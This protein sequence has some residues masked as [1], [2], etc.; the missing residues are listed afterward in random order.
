MTAGA[1]S[2]TVVPAGVAT[3]NPTLRRAVNAACVEVC[4]GRSPEVPEQPGIEAELV[5]AV[6]FHRIAPL[7][8]VALRETRPDLAALLREDRDTALMH[9]VRVTTSL[10][11]ISKTLGDVPWVTFKGPVLSET[12]H[13]A[14]GLRSYGDL[15][16]LVG[17][18]DLREACERLFAVGW[19]AL[20]TQD[21]LLNGEVTGELEIGRT[22][23]ALV[24]LHWSLLLSETQRRR[25]QV[26]TTDLVARSTPLMIGP[27]EVRTLDP[28]DTLLHL[29]HHAARSGAVR[30]VHLLDVDQAARRIL[31]W[32]L[33]ARRARS[34]QA[35][36]QVGLVLARARRVMDTPVPADLDR[37]LGL[38]RTFGRLVSAVDIAWPAPGRRVDASW[39]RRVALASRPSATATASRA[40]QNAVL[41]A[42]HR[43]R[44][45][46][47]A[48]SAPATREDVGAWIGTVEDAAGAAAPGARVIRLADRIRSEERPS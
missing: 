22:G 13:P 28:V 43:A 31:D 37:H 44:P 7:A 46:A 34:W 18:T 26:P 21:D 25:F 35:S 29:C 32:D 8:H 47:K 14:P 11:A 23:S 5:R 15:D 48:P 4:R 45:A 40:L 3:R 10:E 30:L 17:P 6:R 33:V 9:H 12:L 2:D 1:Q 42:V 27:V 41:G 38:S 24:D 39:P 16:I 19:Q 20:A 36:A